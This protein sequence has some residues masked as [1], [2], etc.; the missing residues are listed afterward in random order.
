MNDLFSSF[1]KMFRVAQ[2]NSHNKGTENSMDA[3]ILG[4]CSRKETQCKRQ[5]QH[6][7]RPREFFV[8]PGKNSVQQSASNRKHKRSIS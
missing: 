5:R 7:T 4:E 2:R 6:A 3:N 8:N 1:R